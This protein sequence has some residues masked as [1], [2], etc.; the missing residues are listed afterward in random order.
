MRYHFEGERPWSTGQASAPCQ[1]ASPCVR[2]VA[3]AGCS[4]AHLSACQLAPCTMLF[5]APHYLCRKGLAQLFDAHGFEVQQE[6]GACSMGAKGCCGRS[7]MSCT[8]WHLNNAF[9]CSPLP[10]SKGTGPALRCSWFWGPAGATCM[11]QGCQRVL[12]TWLDVLHLLA[13]FLAPCSTVGSVT[14]PS[15]LLQAPLQE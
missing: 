6:L 1:T 15:E 4:L 11:L 5:C 12:W 10:L 14:P 9:L 8:C 2:A 13:P 7:L 3:P